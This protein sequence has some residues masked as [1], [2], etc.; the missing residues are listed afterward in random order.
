MHERLDLAVYTRLLASPGRH[1]Q[2]SVCRHT[3]LGSH[4]GVPCDLCLSESSVTPRLHEASAE[5][6][7]MT[8]KGTWPDCKTRRSSTAGSALR[9]VAGFAPPMPTPPS[10]DSSADLHLSIQT[11]RLLER[12]VALFMPTYPRSPPDGTLMSSVTPIHK[13]SKFDLELRLLRSWSDLVICWTKLSMT[14]D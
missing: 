10:Q 9:T 8:T 4:P 11:G 13:G 12:P 3:A 14:L 1:R 6:F 2:V 7:F 5:R